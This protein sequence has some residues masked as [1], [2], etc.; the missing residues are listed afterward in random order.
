MEMANRVSSLF[1]CMTCLLFALDW[2]DLA[3]AVLDLDRHN[4]PSYFGCAMCSEIFFAA[5]SR[6]YDIKWEAVVS[7]G[8]CPQLLTP[9]L[10]WVRFFVLWFLATAQM[11]PGA[12]VF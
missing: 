10:N 12:L 2:M 8:S 11:P 3:L 6:K 7:V 4:L 1:I 9:L 5:D